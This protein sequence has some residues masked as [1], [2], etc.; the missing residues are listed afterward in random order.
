MRK[1]AF[2]LVAIVMAASIFTVPSNI[3]Q[4]SA[5]SATMI[6]G[7]SGVGSGCS[8]A[9][10]TFCNDDQSFRASDTITPGAVSVSSGDTVDFI[11]AGFHQ[12]AIYDVGTKPRDIEINGPGPFVNDGN[13]RLAIGATPPPGVDFSWTP[14][15]PGRYLIICD[16]APHFEEARMFGWVNVH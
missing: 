1:Y 12:V 14:P 13:N 3:F 15:G 9:P 2:V 6:F 4:T 10:P 7:L 5:N 16:V 8:P 11:I